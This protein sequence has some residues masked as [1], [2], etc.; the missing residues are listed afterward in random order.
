MNPQQSETFVPAFSDAHQKAFIS[1]GML[2]GHEAHPGCY[3][4]PVLELLAVTDGSD[5]CRGHLGADSAY[6]S[7][8]L[9]TRI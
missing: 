1:A 5:D 7:D 2:S 8:P 9:A 4:P 3:M 6:L